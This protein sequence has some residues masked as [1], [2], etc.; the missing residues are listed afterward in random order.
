[1]ESRK[2]R[3]RNTQVQVVT[4]WDYAEEASPAFKRL[5][6]LLLKP[7]GNKSAET[8]RANEE[9]QNEQ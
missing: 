8:L 4:R 9:H 7:L 2:G 6:M 3:L 1:M 5:M